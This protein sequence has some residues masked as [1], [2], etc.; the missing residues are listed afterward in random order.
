MGECVTPDFDESRKRPYKTGELATLFGVSQRTI[1][2]WIETGRFGDEGKGWRWTPG[3][4]GKG[5]REV[6]AASVKKYFS[7]DA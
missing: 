7:L 3:G 1:I 4:A 2:R 5:D 6:M